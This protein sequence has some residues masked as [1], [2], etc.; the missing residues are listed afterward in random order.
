[1]E[2]R[3]GFFPVFASIR[4]D[5]PA[6]LVIV[7]RPELLREVRALFGGAGPRIFTV[8]SGGRDDEDLFTEEVLR[9]AAAPE[10]KAPA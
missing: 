6:A 1:M 5:P 8:P 7:V 3:K 9:A 10:G 4:R 2:R